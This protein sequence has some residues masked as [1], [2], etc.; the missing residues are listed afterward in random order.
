MCR[1][2]SIDEMHKIAEKRDGKCLS[3]IYINSKTKLNWKCKNNHEWQATSSSIINGTWCFKCSRNMPNINEMYKLAEKKNGKC[4]SASYLNSKSKLL[5]KCNMNHVWK[6]TPNRIKFGTW[7]P[8]CNNGTIEEMHE[9]AEKRGGKCLSDKYIGAHSKLI[10]KCKNG[11]EWQAKP[12]GIK[13]GTWCPICNESHGENKIKNYLISKN[14]IFMRQKKF[15]DC[16]F[17][18]C[19]PFDFYLSEYNILI[20]YDG[21]Q[22]YRTSRFG[23]YLDTKK[24]YYEIKRNDKIKTEYCK[25]NNILLI[26]ISF[27]KK[28]VESYLENKLSCILIKNDLNLK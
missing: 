4:L 1:I 24:L 14:I 23:K 12:N 10:W 27:Y 22:H 28:N 7:C 25:K 9:I 6:A 15:N 3:N 17:I 26:R 21:E 19:L 13:S 16:K 18:R 2:V 20:E 5:W 8:I 11:H